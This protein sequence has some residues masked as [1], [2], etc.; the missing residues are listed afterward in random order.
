MAPQHFT[1]NVTDFTFTKMTA[2]HATWILDMAILQFS[3][4]IQPYGTMTIGIWLTLS[5][6]VSQKLC[7]SIIYSIHVNTFDITHLL[8]IS[9]LQVHSVSARLCLTLQHSSLD[10][11]PGCDSACLG[12]FLLSALGNTPAFS[13]IPWVSPASWFLPACGQVAI[14]RVRCVCCQKRHLIS[15]SAATS[16]LS[17]QS[18]VRAS[19]SK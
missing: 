18:C 7:P 10:W 19:S 6:L 14:A 13:I 4:I 17:V 8:S 11:L 3:L 1:C 16:I 2:A 15:V 9:T 5:I 12:P